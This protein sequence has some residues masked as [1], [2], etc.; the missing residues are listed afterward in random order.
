LKLPKNTLRV[1]GDL[2]AACCASAKP[3]VTAI[4]DQIF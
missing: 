2:A 4:G 1:P 3:L